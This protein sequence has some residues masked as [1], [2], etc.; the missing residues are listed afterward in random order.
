ML[1]LRLRYQSIWVAWV[2]VNPYA[3]YI[4]PFLGHATQPGFWL[5]SFD[6]ISSFLGENYAIF[7][8][9]SLSNVLSNLFS[10]MTYRLPL[11]IN[12]FQ[13]LH[14]LWSGSF[15]LLLTFLMSKVAGWR[16]FPWPS[17]RL[18]FSPY[19]FVI[20]VHLWLAIPLFPLLPL[21]TCLS[22]IDQSGDNLLGFFH[23]PL[24][25]QCHDALVSIAHDALLQDHHG[26]LREQSIASDQSQSWFQSLTLISLSGASYFS[27]AASKA[28]VAGA[29]GEEA[30]FLN[31][32][33]YSVYISSCI[34]IT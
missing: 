5:P 26:V 8:F 14:D 21:C 31:N 32:K 24:R 28:G 6:V 27:S 34:T 18:T 10:Q 17:L 13:N 30:A 15:M 16:P 11:M 20:A 12:Y 4:Q 7:Y 3:L 25:I 33:G 22:V 9:Q 19:E 29:A 23:G 1:G 2:Y